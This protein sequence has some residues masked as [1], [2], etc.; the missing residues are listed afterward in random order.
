M[1]PGRFHSKT[2]TF[3]L[4]TVSEILKQQ[5]SGKVTG[6]LPVIGY[7]LNQKDYCLEVGAQ[8]WWCIHLAPRTSLAQGLAPGISWVFSIC[9]PN[10]LNNKDSAASGVKTVLRMCSVVLTRTASSPISNGR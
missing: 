8:G 3:P 4:S 9:L 2:V 1:K 6:H 10:E 7:N 5:P